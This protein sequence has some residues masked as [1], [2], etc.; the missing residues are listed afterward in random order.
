WIATNDIDKIF[1]SFYRLDVTNHSEIKGTGLGLSI[2]KRLCDLLKIE[3]TLTS[4]IDKGTTFV[5]KFPEVNLK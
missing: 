1:T 4:E 5:L 3:I 2:V